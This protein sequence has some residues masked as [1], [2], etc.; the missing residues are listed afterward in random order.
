MLLYRYKLSGDISP[1]NFG[2]E[3][4]KHPLEEGAPEPRVR[5]KGKG[6]KG[7]GF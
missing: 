7:K 6:G 3:E 5:R 2:L 1:V 4:S